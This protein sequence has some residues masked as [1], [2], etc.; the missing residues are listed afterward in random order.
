MSKHKKRRNG[1]TLV[2][3]LVVIAIIGILIALL[4]PAI[5]SARE[6]ARQV[7]CKSHLR[8]LGIAC[9]SFHSANRHLPAGAYW[10]NDEG[11]QHGN[12]LT[13]LLPFIEE[14]AVFDAYDFTEHSIDHQE[15]PDGT[16]IRNTRIA[17]Y[18]CPSDLITNDDEEVAPQNY[19]ASRGPTGMYANPNRPCQY[20]EQW[21]AEALSEPWT[22]ENHDFFAG[23][24]F[25]DNAIEIEFR[26]I[27]DGL[28]K[29]I[30]FGESRYACSWHTQSG[31]AKTNNG[32]GMVMTLIPINFDSCN[33][34]ATDGC[35]HPFNWSS[36]FGFKSRHP[37]GVHVLMGDSAARFVGDDIDYQIFQYLGAKADGFPAALPE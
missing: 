31:W 35:S 33:E 15:F 9:H 1:F 13:H 7:Q 12:V 23:P 25:R 21:N 6:S 17:I 19:M 18:A 5:Q 27:T 2:E 4:L 10:Y 34:D 36:E 32:Q 28:S 14:Q 3:L 20:V 16:P 22:P 11:V 8:Q 30:F 26:Q 37:G 24:F 29:T